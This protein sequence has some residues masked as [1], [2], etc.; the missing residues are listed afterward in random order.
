MKVIYPWY[1]NLTG[2]IGHLKFVDLYSFVDSF[3]V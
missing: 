3:N 2:F 1:I